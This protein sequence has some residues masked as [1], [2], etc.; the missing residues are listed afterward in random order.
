MKEWRFKEIKQ[1]VPIVV[2]DELIKEEDDQWRFKK[3]VEFFVKINKELDYAS[4]ILVFD[5]SMSAFIPR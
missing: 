2:G 5:E 4:S 3:R 1:F